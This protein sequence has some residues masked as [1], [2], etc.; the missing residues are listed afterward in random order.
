MYNV[1][2]TLSLDPKRRA[3]MCLI[4]MWKMA[5]EEELGRRLL[6]EIP[7]H[8][9]RGRFG[10]LFEWCGKE[11][12]TIDHRS[13]VIAD[14]VILPHHD[15]SLIKP[16]IV[17]ALREWDLK[18]LAA[19]RPETFEGVQSINW[20]LMRKFLASLSPHQAATMVKIWSGAILTK[21]RRSAIFG[22]ANTMCECNLEEQTMHHN[23]MAMSTTLCK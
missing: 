11:G 15:W 14:H 9:N 10:L 3:V 1:L 23:A 7:K 2:S 8:P 22:E 19:R 21:M 20:G 18:R 16:K 12:H 5:T 6:S 4:R 13:L 17:E